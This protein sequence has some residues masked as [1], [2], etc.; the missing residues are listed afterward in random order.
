[1]S[2]N[3]AIP[4][5]IIVAAGVLGLFFAAIEQIAFDNSW[6]LH[7]YVLESE[8]P[9]LQIMTILL[10]MIVGAILAAINT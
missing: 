6:M 5:L 7:L 2:R 10:F 8:L 4:A 9:G 1:M 3:K